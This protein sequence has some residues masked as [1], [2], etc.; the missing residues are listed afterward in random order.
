M[1][2]SQDERRVLLERSLSNEQKNE[3]LITENG[4]LSKKAI[5]TESAL[6]EIAREYQVLQVESSIVTYYSIS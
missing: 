5:E 6:Q 1:S 2:V 3:K 4:L